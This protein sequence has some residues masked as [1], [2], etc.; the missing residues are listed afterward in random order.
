MELHARSWRTHTILGTHFEIYNMHLI[1][2]GSN[3]SLACLDRLF[4]TTLSD[5][6]VGTQM[7]ILS[8]SVC[9]TNQAGI[10]THIMGVAGRRWCRVES[11]GWMECCWPTTL[12]VDRRWYLRKMCFADGTF[13][14]VIENSQC[15]INA[16]RCMKTWNKACPH[17]GRTMLS[18]CIS[19]TV[20]FVTADRAFQALHYWFCLIELTRKLCNLRLIAIHIL[21]RCKFTRHCLF[22]LER[23]HTTGKSRFKDMVISEHESRLTYSP[24]VRDIEQ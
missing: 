9:T 3:T 17:P 13:F 7:C 5:T 6:R 23:R 8:T 16:N 12:K 4:F 21:F 18:L 22:Y 2:R 24:G 1:G 14:G 19:C 20:E 15:T 11:P 10:H